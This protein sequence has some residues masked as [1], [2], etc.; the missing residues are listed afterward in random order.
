MNIKTVDDL[1][2]AYPGLVEKLEDEILEK[3]GIIETS[4]GQVFTEDEKRKVRE[5]AKKLAGIKHLNR[6]EQVLA[7]SEW[8]DSHQEG[9]MLDRAA[10]QILAHP[11]EYQNQSSG[12]NLIGMGIQE[13]MVM[14]GSRE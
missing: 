1:K 8:Q 13:W 6:L 14:R 10:L 5:G 3:L 12:A 7:R 11:L 2:R 9:L 4:E